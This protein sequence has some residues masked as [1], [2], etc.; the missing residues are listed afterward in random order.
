MNH[1]ILIYAWD[2]KQGHINTHSVFKTNFPETA[3]IKSKQRKKHKSNKQRN[4]NPNKQ[5]NAV[6]ELS[7]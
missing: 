1:D 3:E 7:V 2:S 6:E 4:T 5:K